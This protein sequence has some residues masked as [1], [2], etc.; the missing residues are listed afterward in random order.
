MVVQLWTIS[1]LCFSVLSDLD[2]QLLG[3]AVLILFWWLDDGWWIYSDLLVGGRSGSFWRH[4]LDPSIQWS[5]ICW[6]LMS[7]EFV[8]FIECW[9]CWFSGY[10][11]CYC[12]CCGC[13]SCFACWTSGFIVLN[14]MAWSWLTSPIL[15]F[16][17]GRCS[18]VWCRGF[19]FVAWNFLWLSFANS[20]FVWFRFCGFCW[21][22]PANFGLQLRI[23]R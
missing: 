19:Q 21:S 17:D 23:F 9:C 18:L 20:G 1:G 4:K 15:G 10:G 14:L 13:W 6:I 16:Y 7:A 2:Q 5:W 12:R 3:A 22:G 8:G 11:C